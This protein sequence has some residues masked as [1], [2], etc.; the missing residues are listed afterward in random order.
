MVIQDAL[1]RRQTFNI[2]VSQ[3]R[4]IAAITNATRVAKELGCQ[5]G[6]LVGYQ[7]GLDKKTNAEE[8]DKTRLTFC[9]T[10]VITQKLITQ[11][12]LDYYSHIIMGI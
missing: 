5:L 10:G 4:K 11:K 6:G 3:P 12:T 2:L 7:V 8:E 1:I 9:T